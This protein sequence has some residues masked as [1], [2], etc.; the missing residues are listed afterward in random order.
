MK[1]KVR[2][3]SLPQGYHMMPDGTVMKDSAHM[4]E[5][6]TVNKNLPPIPRDMA[7]LEAEK[8]EVAMTD[9]GNTGMMGLYNIGGER[10][11][12]GGTPLNLD[13]GSFIYSDTRKMK[14]KDPEFLAKYGKT[15]PVTPAK[16]VKP[17]LGINDFTNTLYDDNADLIQKRTAQSMIDKYKD[18]AGEIAFYQEAMKGFPQGIPAVAQ[19]YAEGI[20]GASM[21]AYGGY[22]P[23]A[24]DGRTIAEMFNKDRKRFVKTFVSRYPELVNALNS[25]T[26]NGNPDVMARKLQD[27][28]QL[29]QALTAVVQGA[30]SAPAPVSASVKPASTETPAFMQMPTSESQ[31]PVFETNVMGVPGSLPERLL[32]SQAYAAA[33]NLISNIVANQGQTPAPENTT[34]PRSTDDRSTPRRTAG[35]SRSDKFQAINPDLLRVL[36][37]AGLNPLIDEADYSD[38]DRLEYNR[39][40][41]QIAGYP[42]MYEDA[43]QNFPGWVKRMESLGYDFADWKDAEGNFDLKSLKPRDPRV[44]A[45]QEWWN[46]RVDQFI[47]EENEKRQDAGYSAFT[48]AEANALRTQKFYDPNDPN[49]DPGAKIDS[50]LGTYTTTRL[51]AEGEYDMQ[52][53]TVYFCVDGQV[54]GQSVR[55]GSTPTPPSGESVKGPY[56]TQQEAQQNCVGDSSIPVEKQD[57]KKD[58]SKTPLRPFKADVR[59]LNTMVQNRLSEARRYPYAPRLP[60]RLMDAVYLDDTR[61]QQ[62]I[63]G[64][65]KGA[66]D[67]IGAFAGP[68]RQGSMASVLSGQAGEQAADV[69]ATMGNANIN[70]ANSVGQYN[71]RSMGATDQANS[72]LAM[73]LYNDTV[74]TDETYDE[75]MRRYRIFETGLKN[76]LEDNMYAADTYNKMNPLYQITPAA[77]EYYNTGNIQLMPGVSAAMFDPENYSSISERQAEQQKALEQRIVNS[78]YMTPEDKS[79]ALLNVYTGTTGSS[80]SGGSRKRAAASD[81]YGIPGF[82]GA[83]ASMTQFMGMSP[84]EYAQAYSSRYGGNINTPKNKL[85]YKR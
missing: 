44:R 1:R 4:A 55:P 84:E 19:D 62:Q 59:N 83:P 77:G 10:H 47:A 56:K 74:K 58:T 6:G 36:S 39:I 35:P 7:N 16:L 51:L 25:A 65:S 53:D 34:A 46:P 30:N 2:I 61:Q 79:K 76:K 18:K 70:I 50:K 66:L 24:Q 80:S 75:K 21:M 37:Q 9:L 40:Q 15:K 82:T 71:S 42:G 17:F 38:Q 26:F 11:S 14:I 81:A 41:E 69:A 8:G 20:M 45:Y 54:M 60:Y 67:A 72:L 43:M 85:K 22:I 5:G 64:R 68:G 12:N 33:P 23:K 31:R 13:P 78:P 48:E 27:N 73:N 49:S 63:A 28:P 32:I 29:L 3:K 52:A 57:E